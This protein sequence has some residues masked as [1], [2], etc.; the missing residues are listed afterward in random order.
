M[1]GPDDQA[2]ALGALRRPPER[3]RALG[4]FAD[5]ALADRVPQPGPRAAL[6]ILVGTAGEP[7]VADVA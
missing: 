3:D 4:A 2:A 1:E 6:A 7:L 5:R